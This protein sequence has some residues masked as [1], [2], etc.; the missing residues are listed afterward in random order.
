MINDGAFQ[1]FVVIAGFVG[2][3]FTA[4]FAKKTVDQFIRLG[5]YWREGHRIRHE[6]RMAEAEAAERRLVA[7][8]ERKARQ[9]AIDEAANDKAYKEY[10]RKLDKRNAEL[11]AIVQAKTEG[12]HL[13]REELAALK[14]EIANVREDCREMRAELDKLRSR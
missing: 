2:A 9:R 4:V 6:Q 7:A 12:E 1:Q 8:E 5:N 3:A 10:I 13:C 14:V 11:E